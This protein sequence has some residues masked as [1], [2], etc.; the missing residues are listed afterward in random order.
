MASALTDRRAATAARQLAYHRDRMRWMERRMEENEAAL[1]SYLTL[2]GSEAATLPGGYRLVR[3]DSG[4]L[5]VEEPEPTT[6]YEQLE[7]PVYG[8]HDG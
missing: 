1:E 6:R 2:Q 8:G 5:V 4:G 3:G 7:L